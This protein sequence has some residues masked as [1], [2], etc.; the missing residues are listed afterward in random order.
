MPRASFS[1]TRSPSLPTTRDV[2]S[3]NEPDRAGQPERDPINVM[4][5]KDKK[6]PAPKASKGRSPL[7]TTGRTPLRSPIDDGA[8]SQMFN[9]SSDRFNSRPL[10]ARRRSGGNEPLMS[11]DLDT[12]PKRRKQR[13][14][15]NKEDSPSASLH[16]SGDPNLGI[17]LENEVEMKAQ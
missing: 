5:P 1:L 9:L 11:L 10:P 16:A 8:R 2:P 15:S 17:R 4:S 3:S 13:G 6:A 14:L 12:P 7:V